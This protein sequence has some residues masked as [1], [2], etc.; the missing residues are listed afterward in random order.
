[1]GVTVGIDLRCN[2]FTMEGWK[3]VPIS[4]HCGVME[5]KKLLNGPL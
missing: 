3:L 4:D 2:K 5:Q 1:V